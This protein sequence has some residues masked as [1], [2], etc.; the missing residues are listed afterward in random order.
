M[1]SDSAAV[2]PVNFQFLGFPTVSGVCGVA[3]SEQCGQCGKLLFFSFV[4]SPIAA[5]AITQLLKHTSDTFKTWM[6]K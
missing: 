2:A 6:P 1:I 3:F 5:V 4:L